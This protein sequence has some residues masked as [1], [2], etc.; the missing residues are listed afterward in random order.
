MP[1]SPS[2]FI[3]PRTMHESAQG[4]SFT[5]VY[6]EM[7]ARRELSVVGSID[8]AMA[9][10]LCQQMRLLEARD[11]TAPH[12]AIHCKPRRLG[13]QRAG[14]LRHDANRHVPRAH[15]VPGT[16]RLHGIHRLHGRRRTPDGTACRAH[17]PR[18][19]HP[20]WR[21]RLGSRSAGNKPSSDANAPN[22][23]ADPSRAQR[24]FRPAHPHHD[25]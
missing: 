25:R 13:R 17:D 21:R 8:Q 9:H 20:V 10:D 4:F 7:L 15:R 11:H 2:I 18:P 24:A 3:S 23:H 19:A 14:H 5:T 6:D 1:D 16:R 12:H 22:A